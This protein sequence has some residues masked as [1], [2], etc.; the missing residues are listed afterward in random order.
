[1]KTRFAVVSCNEGES[2]LRL[3]KLADTVEQAVAA[4]DGRMRQTQLGRLALVAARPG[5]KPAPERYFG[6]LE[7]VGDSNV[8]VGAADAS[9]AQARAVALAAGRGAP[10]PAPVVQLHK[11]QEGTDGPWQ[12]PDAG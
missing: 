12:P 5:S 1:M 10:A 4:R 7:M 3:E 9:E 2:Y 6:I 8:Q 11:A